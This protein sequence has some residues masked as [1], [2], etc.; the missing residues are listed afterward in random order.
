MPRLTKEQIKNK[1]D[2]H[3]RAFDRTQI[4][5]DPLEFPHRFSNLYDIEI[6]AF[7]ASV[8]AYGNIKQIMA[9]LENIFEIIGES[10]YD[11]VNNYR[12]KK[13]SK[14]FKNVTHRFYTPDDTAALFDIL[15]QVYSAYGSLKYMFL[16]YY[17]AKEPNLKNSISLFSRNHL[18]IASRHTNITNG[19]K[20][21]FPDPYKNSPCKRMNLF[22]RWMIRKDELDFGLWKEITTDK[23]VIPVD[24]HIAAISRELKL[25]KRKNVSW[26]MAE[27]ITENLKKYNADDP[28]KY[29]FAL[30]HIGMRKLI[31]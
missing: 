8:F 22:L 31:F 14:Y 7:I 29:D 11:F 5:P 6:S 15:N 28:V 19:L 12:W 10:P 30:C 9:T 2:Y 24:T 17:F 20:F 1:L 18:D 21:M 13:N 23:L 27:E 3:Y 26:L 16:L 25:T 4:S